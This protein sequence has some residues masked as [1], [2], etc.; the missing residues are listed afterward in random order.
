VSGRTLDM[1]TPR[2]AP[3]MSSGTTVPASHGRPSSRAWAARSAR[4]R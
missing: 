4:P 2:S 1:I 3:S